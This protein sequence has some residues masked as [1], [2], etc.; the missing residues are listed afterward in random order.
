MDH[1]INYIQ[2]WTSNNYIINLEV[3]VILILNS[4]FFVPYELTTKNR[5][6]HVL[7][8]VPLADL[9]Y[10]IIAQLST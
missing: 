1:D 7:K 9:N 2:Y 3:R 5:K 6:Q 8:N 10:M 4:M